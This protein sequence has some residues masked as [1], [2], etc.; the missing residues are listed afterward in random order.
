MRKIL[1]IFIAVIPLIVSFSTSDPTLAIRF[2][3]LSFIVSGLLIYYLLANKSIYK[4]VVTNHAMLAFA[5]VIIA[6]IFSA[7][8]NGFGSES[9]YNILKLFLLYVFSIIVIQFVI[10]EGYKSLINS[11]IFFSLFLSAI[12]FY[13]IITNYSDIMSIKSDW[14]RNHEFDTIA[15][16]MGHKNLLSSIQFLML[17]I[18]IFILTFSKR[19]LK[20]LSGLAIL[21]ILITIFQTQT[22]AVLFSVGIFSISLLLLNK[23]NLHKKHFIGLLVGSVLMLG[24]AYAIMKYT[25][26]H[27]PF[28]MEI[29]K[30]LNFTSSSRYK[31]YN[32][33]FQLIKDHPVF[34]VGPGNWKIDVWE[35][36]LYIG[37][38]GKSFAQR[39]HNDFVWVFS[40]GG[41]IAGLSYILIFLI[42]LRDSYYL[43]KN[44]KEEDGIF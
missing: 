29:N 18:L 8:Y 23:I 39:P 4:E 31:L 40:E 13:Q 28:L 12:Y 19:V 26:R 33:S 2:L 36:G 27:D 32:S 25:N 14:Q 42:L 30:I 6:Y 21:L 44:R 20:I 11:F 9:I 7:F 1:Q 3:A 34:G 10:K 24:C 5:L 37:T 17:P 38:S 22:R 35:Y 16:T 15:A 43:H 41:F